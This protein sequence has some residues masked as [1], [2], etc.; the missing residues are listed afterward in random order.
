MKTVFACE[1]EEAI[2]NRDRNDI[3]DNSDN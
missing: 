3:M 1:S 2:I